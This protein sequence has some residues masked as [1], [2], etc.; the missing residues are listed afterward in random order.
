MRKKSKKKKRINNKIKYLLTITKNY[1]MMM[2]RVKRCLLKMYNIIKI[3][4]QEN[5]Q[6]KLIMKKII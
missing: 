6:L 5:D 1:L 2:F 3:K 4:I